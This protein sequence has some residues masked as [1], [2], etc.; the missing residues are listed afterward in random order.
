MASRVSALLLLLLVAVPVE[1]AQRAFTLA[2]AIR[3]ALRQH[4]L[5]QSAD[6]D[7]EVATARVA[8][9]RSGFM[10]RLSLTAGSILFEE[11]QSYR[12]PPGGMSIDLSSDPLFGAL[13]KQPISNPKELSIGVTNQ[14]LNFGLV[15]LTQP[16]FTGGMILSYHRMARHGRDAARSGKERKVHEVVHTVIR[17]YHDAVLASRL[18]EIGERALT[19]VRT[20]HGITRRVHDAG[21]PKVNRLDYL[22]SKLTAATV[23]GVVE[24][25]REGRRLALE[26]LRF[27]IGLEPGQRVRPATLELVEPPLS[28]QCDAAVARALRTRPEVA[29]LESGVKALRA[30]VG[31][32]W[33][34]YLPDLALTAG[35]L[36]DDKS[37]RFTDGHTFYAALVARFTLFEGLHTRAEVAEARARLASL[38]HKRRYLASG[39]G[40][41]V[42]KNCI[43]RERARSELKL[44]RE[45]LADAEEYLALAER[46]YQADLI[47]FDEVLK[48]QLAEALAR[49]QELKVRYDLANSVADWSRDVGDLSAYSRGP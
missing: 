6:A 1:A 41:Q 29:Q 27:A 44:A 20:V 18:L 38:E 36:I 49:A 40:A 3:T 21:S 43:E 46:S 22:K 19:R 24:K 35:Y 8:R 33:S 15:S 45:S 13:L 34:R 23:A 25:L 9:A 10:P 16:L 48:A 17:R 39:I 12:I 37:I 26:G 30:G 11:A 5:I 14:W 42:R 28:E 4:A 47:G 31:A 7:V 32:A 2:E